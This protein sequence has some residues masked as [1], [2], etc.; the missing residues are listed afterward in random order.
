[1]CCERGVGE[2]GAVTCVRME[3]ERA[4]SSCEGCR[5]VGTVLGSC[6]SLAGSGEAETPLGPVAAG[7]RSQPTA[8]LRWQ[9]W[10]EL[11]K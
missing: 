1:M 10:Q 11:M 3:A 4:P 7:R 6:S 8:V 9:R 5:S 2:V